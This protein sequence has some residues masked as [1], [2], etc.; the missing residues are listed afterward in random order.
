MV[1]LECELGFLI[2]KNLPIQGVTFE[3]PGTLS[4]R[5]LAQFGPQASYS[6]KSALHT[7]VTLR[8]RRLNTSHLYDQVRDHKLSRSKGCTNV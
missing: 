1:Q 5:L 2:T 6:V 8:R 3:A 7:S 4:T